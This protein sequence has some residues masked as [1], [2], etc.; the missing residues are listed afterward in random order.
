VDSCQ[1]LTQVLMSC[2]SGLLAHFPFRAACT[3]RVDSSPTQS[4]PSECAKH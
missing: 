3:V 1:R 2:D 4:M